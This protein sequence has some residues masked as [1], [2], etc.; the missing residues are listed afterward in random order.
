MLASPEPGGRVEN[1]AGFSFDSGFAKAGFHGA[2]F[3][4]TSVSAAVFGFGRG[5]LPFSTYIGT[6]LRPRLI[7]TSNESI[8]LPPYNSTSY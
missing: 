1:E 5:L 4:L 7:S 6:L 8:V 2:G 3:C